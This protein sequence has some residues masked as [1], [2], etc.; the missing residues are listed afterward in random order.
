METRRITGIGQAFVYIPV[1]T[2]PRINLTDSTFQ[3]NSY[4]LLLGF[5]STSDFSY[6]YTKIPEI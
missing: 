4:Y 1:L 5:P 6:F 3:N 2:N